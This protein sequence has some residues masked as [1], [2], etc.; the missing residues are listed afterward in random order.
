MDIVEIS[1]FMES[2]KPAAPV[3]DG[4]A[5]HGF[6]WFMSEL[7]KETLKDEKADSQ[8][9][10]KPN[11]SEQKLSDKKSDDKEESKIYEIDEHQKGY[12]D[13]LKDL[14]QEVDEVDKEKS[15]LVRPSAVDKVSWSQ[16]DLLL[17]DLRERIS[18]RVALEVAK[19]ITPEF[20]EKVIREEMAKMGN[21]SS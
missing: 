13:F 7:K 2:L 12:E 1:D 17:S 5:V 19:K 18:E 20:L 15:T 9:E 10:E 8:L 21:D 6:H 4:E 3:S 16:F 11:L 14:K